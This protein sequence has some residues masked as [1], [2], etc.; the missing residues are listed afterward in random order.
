M[1][2][3]L[4]PPC[5]LNVAYDPILIYV[6]LVIIFYRFYYSIVDAMLVGF[7]I[8]D[9]TWVLYVQLLIMLN[10]VGPPAASQLHFAIY[11]TM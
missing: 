9:M 2:M 4:F 3:T 7:Y 6:R 11:Y 1:F 10:F 8:I 5:N